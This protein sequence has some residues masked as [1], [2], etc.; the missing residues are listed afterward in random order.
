MKNIVYQHFDA[1]CNATTTKIITVVFICMHSKNKNEKGNVVIFTVCVCVY[2]SVDIDEDGDDDDH[3]ENGRTLT[4][5]NYFLT[6]F[7]LYVRIC[8]HT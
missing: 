4:H 7:K 2:A 6:I 3:D 1:I 8:I 5:S